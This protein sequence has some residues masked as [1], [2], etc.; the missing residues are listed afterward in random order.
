MRLWSIHPKYLDAKG[1]SALWREALLA[2]AVLLGK[3]RGY[4]SHPQLER[5]RSCPK[6]IA[7]INAFL[8]GVFEESCARGY[9]FDKSKASGPVFRRSIPVTS[10]QLGFEFLHLKKKLSRRSPEKYKELCLVKKPEPHPLFGVKPGK[11]G[12]WEKSRVP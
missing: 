2:K 10:G 9:C 6:P 1:L 5:F 12:D 11:R 7:A 4:K 3:T 8:L